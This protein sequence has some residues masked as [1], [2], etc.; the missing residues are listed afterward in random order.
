MGLF[1]FLSQKKAP[2]AASSSTTNE[3][4]LINT[5]GKLVKEDFTVVGVHYHEDSMKKLACANE[6]WRKSAKTIISE[7]KASERIFHYSY[8]NKPVKIV[9]D[10]KGIYDKNALMVLIAGEHVGYIPNDDTDHVKA[11]LSSTSIKYITASIRG[12]EYKIVS[13]KG[14]TVKSDDRLRITVRIAYA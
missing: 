10:E 4:K 9:P 2:S 11:I 7:G 3:Q 1:D 13:T 5:G 8:I 12:G 6:D 14:D